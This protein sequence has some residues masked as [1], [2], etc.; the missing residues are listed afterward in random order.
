MVSIGDPHCA[1]GEGE[2]CGPAIEI[3]AEAT[4]RSGLRTPGAGGFLPRLPA[5][6]L[7]GHGGD[8]ARGA[9][10]IT[11]G[12]PV[13]DDGTNA[14]LDLTLAARQALLEMLRWLSAERGLSMEQGYVLAS[15]AADLRIAEAVNRPNGLV[16]CRLALDVFEEEG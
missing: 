8:A 11:T 10:M 5:I 3:A 4:V 1:Q 2:C 15:V 16:V 12:I 13:A 6:E 14:D 7:T 9:E